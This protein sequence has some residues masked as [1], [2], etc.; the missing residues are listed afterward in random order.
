MAVIDFVSQGTLG[1]EILPKR[2]DL[3]IFRGDTP[4]FTFNLKDSEGAALDLTGA[5]AKVEIK[6]KSEGS[7]GTVVTPGPSVDS[8]NFATGV[9]VIEFSSEA[10]N[11]MAVASQPTY[12]E[13]LIW[14]L[15]I[16]DSGGNVRT[17][18]GGLID[19][20]EDIVENVGA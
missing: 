13:A 6:T 5:T 15:E 4:K 10:T 16:T 18:L 11:A 17:Y 1:E 2:Y 14:E 3:S 9:V 7:E 20:H 12:I 19:M 8:T